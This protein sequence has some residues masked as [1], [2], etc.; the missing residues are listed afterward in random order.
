MLFS[1]FL[2]PSGESCASQRGALSFSVALKGPNQAPG[3]FDGTP[4][5]APPTPGLAFVETDSFQS[6]QVDFIVF[7]FSAHAFHSLGPPFVSS[8]CWRWSEATVSEPWQGLG[9]LLSRFLGGGLTQG[10][11]QER[12]VA[13]QLLPGYFWYT[14]E[15]EA[16]KSFRAGL[17][18]QLPAIVS[19]TAQMKKLQTVICRHDNLRSCG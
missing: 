10:K 19:K 1:F 16:A 14:I 15:N 8:Y 7:C 5:L 2:C 18:K 11:C 4:F 13:I 9:A 6:I 3:R 17:S 12:G